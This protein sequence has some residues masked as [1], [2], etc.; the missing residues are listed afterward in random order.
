MRLVVFALGRTSLFVQEKKAP[1]FPRFRNKRRLKGL[2]QIFAGIFPKIFATH[3]GFG[4]LPLSIHWND[5]SSSLLN[6]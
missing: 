5:R 3:C 4:L 6:G 2:P 1:H